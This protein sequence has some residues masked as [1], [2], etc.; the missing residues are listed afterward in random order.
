MLSPA[1]VCLTSLLLASSVLG[2]QTTSEPEPEP[3]CDIS[4]TFGSTQ[5]NVS[6]APCGASGL[7]VLHYDISLLDLSL[8][9]F[10]A[11]ATVECREEQCDYTFELVKPCL[12]Y[13]ISL[14]LI[15]EDQTNTY[16]SL[17]GRAGEEIPGAVTLD[18]VTEGFT[19]NNTETTESSISISWS[20]PKTGRNNKYLY[21]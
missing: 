9:T 4:A 15:L 2:Q 13:N 5:I 6:W 18:G 16:N 10:N 19:V 20:A 8:L 11:T 12:K 14:V 1:R 7:E 21:F 17:A 3:G